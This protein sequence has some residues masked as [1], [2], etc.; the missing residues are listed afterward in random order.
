[1]GRQRRKENFPIPPAFIPQFLIS[2][3]RGKDER[4]GRKRAE[5]DW[6]LD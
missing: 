4:E 2:S 3:L 6:S 1:M 5:K